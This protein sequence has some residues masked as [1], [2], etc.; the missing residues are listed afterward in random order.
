LAV[1]AAAPGLTQIRRPAAKIRPA[2]SLGPATA[3]RH[4]G[5]TAEGGRRASCRDFVTSM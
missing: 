1:Y 4:G 5:F 3:A 2:S